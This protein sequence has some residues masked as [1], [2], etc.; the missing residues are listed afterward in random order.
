MGRVVDANS[1]AD[2]KQ[3]AGDC[4]HGNVCGGKIINGRIT[5]T[6][7]LM[8]FVTLRGIPGGL[9]AIFLVGDEFHETKILCSLLIYIM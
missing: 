3:S 9:L 6:I 1:D 4:V 7:N 2:D 8:Q 5:V